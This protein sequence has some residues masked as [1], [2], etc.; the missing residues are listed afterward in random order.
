MKRRQVIGL[1]VVAAVVVPSAF[2]VVVSRM[3]PYW[4]YIVHKG[5]ME[6]TISSR[7]AVIVREHSYDV[8]Q[9]ISS[10]NKE[11]WSL[12]TSFGS[13]PMGPQSPKAMRTRALIRG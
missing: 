5:S 6:P 10:T 1:V 2:L 3:L 8:G 4:V 11:A 9:T 13:S 12:I 7:S